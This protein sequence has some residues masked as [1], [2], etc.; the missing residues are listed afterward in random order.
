MTASRRTRARPASPPAYC[1][2]VRALDNGLEIV[3]VEMPHLHS[4]QVALLARVGSRHERPEDN[5]LSHVLEHMFFRGC[6]GFETSTALNAA[7]EDLGG[8][9]DGYTTRDHSGYPVTVHPRHVGDAVDILGLM[10]GR[11]LFGDFD[12]EKR[13]ILEEMLDALDDRGR[14]IDLDTLAHRL[15]FRDHPLGQSIEGPRKNVR[16]FTEGDLERHR[17]RF[18]GA[19]N[20]VLCFAGR[21][22]PAACVRAAKR[23]FG[24]FPRGRR[25]RDGRPPP[26]PQ[27]G[28]RARN[29]DDPQTRLR[30][31]FRGASD[32][33]PDHPAL[34]LLRR[35]L[36]GGLSARLPTEMVE[37]R[38]L[39]Y[40][41]GSDLVT[42]GDTGLL[43][44][45]IV[46]A[47]RKLPAAIA[48]L[49]D[50]L[51]EIRDHPPSPEELDRVRARVAI[52]VDLG[53]DS[54]T[55]MVQWFGVDHLFGR[56]LGPEDR[57]ARLTEVTPAD[58]QRVARA[59]LRGDRL[60]AVAVGGARPREIAAARKRIAEL[61]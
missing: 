9:L 24:G 42:Y 59:Y 34:S 13:I 30:L 40:E 41:V 5:G 10:F 48:T 18:Y 60:T 37:K 46:V 49:K 32:A 21:I 51:H 22:D 2:Q 23:A 12:V 17:R 33:H 35:I 1:R 54:A 16:R 50:V 38:G 29:T 6:D 28:F 61:A 26:R 43:D 8:H 53:L 11:P 7:M 39:A 55:E 57:L 27:P 4:A 45:E 44:F 52:G 20:L 3:T 15:H 31:S 25:S 56:A 14:E 47:H 58:I 36:D 19:S